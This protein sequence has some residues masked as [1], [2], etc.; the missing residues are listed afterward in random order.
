MWPSY[1]TNISQ[2]LECFALFTNLYGENIPIR[3]G[4][5]TQDRATYDPDLDAYV[6][7][8]DPDPLIPPME[9]TYGP[10][11]FDLIGRWT[12]APLNNHRHQTDHRPLKRCR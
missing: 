10:R 12:H 7:Y 9:V 1:M 6:S 4:G 3:I 2:S 5:T 8:D 11:F